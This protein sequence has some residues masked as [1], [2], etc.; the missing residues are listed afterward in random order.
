MIQEVD[1]YSADASGNTW[2]SENIEEAGEEVDDFIISRAVSSSTMV[3]LRV[4]IIF[5]KLW[6]ID[7]PQYTTSHLIPIWCYSSERV[8]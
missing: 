5:K 2:N 1:F 6:N 7:N 8:F 3:D 4:S